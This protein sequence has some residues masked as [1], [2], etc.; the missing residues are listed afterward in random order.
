MKILSVDQIRAADRY[1]IEHEPVASVEL[2][3]RAARSVSDQIMSR[4]SAKQSLM[5]FCGTGNNGG[6]G[7]VIARHLLKAGFD[8]EAFVI[9]FSDRLSDDAQFNYDRLVANHSGHLNDVYQE[10]ELPEIKADS[11]LIDALFGSGL[12][13]AVSGLAAK[14]INRINASGAIV[15]AVDMPSGLKA[16]HPCDT[17]NEAIVKADYVFSFEV[18]K[19]AFFFA[20][21]EAFVGDWSVF[22]IGLHSGFLSKLETPYQSLEASF[23]RSLMPSRSKFSHKGTFGHA[24]LFAG[25]A[26]KTGAAI[27]AAT[28][29]L[30]SGAGLLHVHL[31]E[32]S[33]VAMHCALPEAMISMDTNEMHSSQLPILNSFNVIGAGPG[34]GTHP[35]TEKLLKLLIQECK[36]PLVLD[37][38]AL[39][40][41]SSNK[42]WMAFLPK[43]TIL[44]PHPKEFERLFGKTSNS[45]ERLELQRESAKKY[46]IIIILKGSYTCVSAA[47]GRCW[48]N[49]TG[50]PGMATA[51]SGD[52]LTGII[53]GL[54]AQ[55]YQP[56]HAALAGVFLHGMAGDI[57]A[58]ENGLEGL[59]ASDL[60]RSLGQ[61]FLRLRSNQSVM[62]L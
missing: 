47:D 8:V 13:K 18:P 61:A 41:L 17:R 40:I 58:R 11:V 24:L 4:V 35:D 45:F 28:A 6:D 20:E 43:N 25:S 19:L 14:T 60:C 46:G 42:T 16:D 5:I 7:L 59:I 34:W 38:D 31:P 52:V 33:V 53:V 26:G 15:I 29:C 1:T 12:N 27:L 54:L 57:A 22:P 3:E 55:A 21:N 37:A 36:V 10:A 49:T 56:L 30:R 9:R 44:T 32:Q 50:N 51:G 48:F 23:I 39:N 2:M 62:D